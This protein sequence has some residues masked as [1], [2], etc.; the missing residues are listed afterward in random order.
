M[1]APER[2]G[3]LFV[4]LGN[5][6]RSPMAEGVFLHKINARGLAARFH[7]DSAGTGGWHVGAP[8]D[9]RARTVARRHGV[10]LP[11]R[12]RVI[13]QADFTRF[14]RLLCMDESNRENLLELGAPAE[15]THLLLE[16]A[17][18]QRLLEVPDP[19][20]GDEQD[21][22]TVF[23]LVDPACDGLIDFLIRAHA[24]D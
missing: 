4:C 5:I 9:H 2:V 23:N 24:I 21:F 6:C 12:A 16:F 8:A 15:R 20:I 17:A 10:V 18:N 19:Y 11:S 3:V 7:V 22:E 1:S 14:H 13:E